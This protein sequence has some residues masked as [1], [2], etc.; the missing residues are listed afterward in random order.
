MNETHE[1]P[2]PRV[3]FI[4][5]PIDTKQ[6]N[7]VQT[8]LGETILE[9]QA[10]L[11]EKE[12]KTYHPAYL[13][14]EELDILRQAEQHIHTSLAHK[15]ERLGVSPH[16]RTRVPDA[17][18]VRS[19]I[20]KKGKPDAAGGAYTA[21]GFPLVVIDN[22]KD[23][24]KASIT[25]AHE[26]SHLATQREIWT[27]WEEQGDKPHI[28]AAVA[29]LGAETVANRERLGEGI[30]NGLAILDSVDIY[31]TTLRSLFPKEAQRRKEAL[32]SKEIQ[33]QIQQLDRSVFGPVN[34]S[35]IEPFLEFYAMPLSGTRAIIH[36]KLWHN[37][38]LV[39]ELCRTIAFSTLQP[40]SVPSIPP[41]QRIDLGRALL[42]KDR[43]TGHHDGLREIVRIFGPKDALSILR[44]KDDGK[45][46]D[47][48]MKLIRAKQRE[49]GMQ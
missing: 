32:A 6:E 30:E 26:L 9:E 37:A 48:A 15:M 31:N 43:F 10:R 46:L 5:L 49:L 13:T 33:R 16:S 42:D 44:L 4:G 40:S 29:K 38:R 3:R 24:L 27:Y 47:R 34:R 14:P 17:S 19:P 11:R 35:R 25:A 45:N 39:E 21:F 1:S 28:T 8:R 22:A 2:A 41:Q 20:K 7:L 18:Y 12:V 23:L 36:E